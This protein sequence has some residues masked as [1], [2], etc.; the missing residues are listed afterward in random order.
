M[1]HESIR[2]SKSQSKDA[3][4][5]GSRRDGRLPV[6][7]LLFPVLV[8][9]GCLI[10]GLTM[11]TNYAVAFGIS[12]EY[13]GKDDFESFLTWIS[14]DNFGGVA[15][16]GFVVG[17]FFGIPKVVILAACGL[18]A[19]DARIYFPETL[20]AY[21]VAAIGFFLL[22]M[23]TLFV[24]ESGSEAEDRVQAAIDPSNSSLAVAFIV[25]CIT[26]GMRRKR[27]LLVHSSTPE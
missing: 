23:M 21:A 19:E 13:F 14:A 26:M 4:D 8:F 18:L 11:A 12:P 25:A 5:R 2:Q 7:L 1:R 27:R 10:A 24:F 22:T 6:K 15:F 3:E 16:I 17:A 9:C 20:I